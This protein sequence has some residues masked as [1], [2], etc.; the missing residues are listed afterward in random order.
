MKKRQ[1]IVNFYGEGGGTD[2][3]K[4]IS[5]PFTVPDGM[6]AHVYDFVV[7]GD[8]ECWFW[9]STQ[10][11][12]NDHGG[13]FASMYLVAPGIMGFSPEKPTVITGQA[14]IYCNYRTTSPQN[15]RD[16]SNWKNSL[17]T[18]RW[19]GELVEEGK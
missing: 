14:K 2:I 10:K 5:E 3:E 11:P 1:P 19:I 18:A 8:S 12:N 7:M 9:L 4:I 15:K 16:F 13:H 6:M 17:F